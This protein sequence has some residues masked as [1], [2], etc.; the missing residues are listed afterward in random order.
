MK[1][2]LLAFAFLLLLPIWG[3]SQKI[4]L[5]ASGLY[6]VQTESMGLG[7]RINVF[8]NSRISLVPQFSHYSVLMGTISEWTLGLS[9]EAKTIRIN[10][11]DLYLMAHSGYNNWSN[12]NSS[13]LEGAT[14][15]NWNLEGG[16]GITTNWCLR[17]FLEYRYNLKFQETHLQ[18][19]LLY[20]FG[21]NGNQGGMNTKRI[22]RKVA[23]PAYN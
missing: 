11:F 18:L 23:C 8:P 15:T 21:C 6:N 4:G 20:V 14:T 17:P 1:K 3:F 19:G 22:N 2:I 9:V 13:P 5:G 16:A 12:A 7:A 10:T